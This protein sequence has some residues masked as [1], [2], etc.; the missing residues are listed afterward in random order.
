MKKIPASILASLTALLLL[1]PINASCEEILPA[2]Q[3]YA[4]AKVY[5]ENKDYD[6]AITEYLKAIKA[7]HKNPE[8]YNGLGEAYTDKEQYEEAI[9]AYTK[10]IKLAAK[11]SAQE[12]AKYY[13]NRGVAYYYQ[14]KYTQAIGDYTQAIGFEDDNPEHYCNR[15]VA[16]YYLNEL[17]KAEQDYLKALELNPNHLDTLINMAELALTQNDDKGVIEYYTKVLKFDRQNLQAYNNR[18]CAYERTGEYEKA[19]ADM[20]TAIDIM[21][22]MAVLRRNYATSCMNLHKYPEALENLQRAVEIKDSKRHESY[23]LKAMC[24]ME[25]GDYQAALADINSAKELSP[26]KTIYDWYYASLYEKQGNYELALKYYNRAKNYSDVD[27]FAY[28]S[29]ASI[30]A[31]QNNKQ[32][33]LADFNKGIELCKTKSSA[34]SKI[35]NQ[36]PAL[37]QISIALIYNEE[38]DY[39]QSLNYLTEAIKVKELDFNTK[40]T[41][42]R[43]II[44]TKALIQ[45]NN[46]LQQLLEEDRFGHDTIRQQ[47]K[48]KVLAQ[49]I[50]T[51]LK[52]VNDKGLPADILPMSLRPSDQ[53][54]DSQITVPVI[55]G[56]P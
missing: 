49:E 24:E 26:G 31:K 7:D 42:E 9:E 22:D 8:Y 20:K 55:G 18:A 47:E 28:F 36:L 30:Y 52:A 17:P 29:A 2:A 37:A 6:A 34:E 39:E 1:A 5:Y 54:K 25:T 10:A 32:A 3:S 38:E 45:E 11:K 33:A 53:H 40:Q 51:E 56:L 27:V 48:V 46:K 35:S 21:P 44:R 23:L 50:N 12:K 43:I 41:V 13:D 16:Y 4:K 19:L 14:K 15:G